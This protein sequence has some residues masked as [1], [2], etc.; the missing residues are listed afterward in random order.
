M[1][2]KIVALVA[3]SFC[4]S[5]AAVRST[6]FAQKQ[7]DDSA[8]AT[9]LVHDGWIQEL[10]ERLLLVEDQC[11]AASDKLAVA[12][13]D[14]T[15]CD[16]QKLRNEFDYKLGEASVVYDRKL[17]VVNAGLAKLKE[18]EKNN[19]SISKRM[20][21]VEEALE[22]VK[23]KMPDLAEVN[24][25]LAEL[26]E[27]GE[28]SRTAM[29]IVVKELNGAKTEL[30]TIKERLGALQEKFLDMQSRLEKMQSDVALKQDRVLFA[31]GLELRATNSMAGFGLR[32]DMEFQR[33]GDWCWPVYGSSIGYQ[34]NGITF[35]LRVL[36]KC[37][38]GP[39]HIGFGFVL[40]PSFNKDNTASVGALSSLVGF[41][42]I[43]GRMEFFFSGG[44]GWRGEEGVYEFTPTLETAIQY[45]F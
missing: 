37:G 25:A 10:D 27:T 14:T 43:S 12:E 44:A 45:R 4:L 1:F 38:A 11:M 26:K 2:K 33:R 17:A 31:V 28:F 29:N 5:F 24:R 22:R 21:G 13:L 16:P 15:K 9:L 30:E 3:F 23:A 39:F 20:G 40:T 8:I 35:S 34:N 6:V 36:G 18:A 7:L 32:T 42:Y 19:T 41:G